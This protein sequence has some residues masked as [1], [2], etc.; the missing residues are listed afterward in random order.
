VDEALNQ[1]VPFLQRQQRWT[2]TADAF[3]RLLKW[4]DGGVDSQG[5]KYEEIRLRLA[6]F[7]ER[8]DCPS[9]EDLVDETFNRVMKWLA[10]QDK[11]H[12][13]EPAKICYNTAR[14]VFHESLRKPDRSSDDIDALPPSGQP[15]VDPQEIAACEEE[16]QEK[17]KRLA[18][19]ERCSQKLPAGD[20]D[21]IIDYYYGEQGT[22]IAQRKAMAEARGVRVAV[23]RNHAYRIRERL[24]ECVMRCLGEDS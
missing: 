2:P 5:Q 19:L 13:P 3:A 12:D 14:F 11:D 10:E 21:L 24:K 17:E 16:Q 4:L 22:K 9:P 20:D 23:L 6:A 8:K 7:F 18:C 15:F 1:P